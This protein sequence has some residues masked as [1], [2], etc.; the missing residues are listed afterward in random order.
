M[1]LSGLRA[2]AVRDRENTPLQR[3]FHAIFMRPMRLPVRHL[4]KLLQ[5]CI[6]YERALYFMYFLGKGQIT[7]GAPRWRP[8][9][10]S[11]LW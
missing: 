3:A 1:H 4:R 5:V 10:F 2:R 11:I 7:E 8:L 6:V 9:D